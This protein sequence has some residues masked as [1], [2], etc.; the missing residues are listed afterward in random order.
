MILPIID[1]RLLIYLIAIPCVINGWSLF[2]LNFFGH[3]STF[4]S[5]RNYKVD[6]YGNKDH[7]TNSLWLNLVTGGEGMQNN[8]HY[9][10]LA[11]NFK[12]SDKWHETDFL[13]TFLIEKFLKA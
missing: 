11:Y 2:L 1:I 4:G 3:L 7:S 10:P 13:N 8:H 9:D 5:Y 12:M 6:V